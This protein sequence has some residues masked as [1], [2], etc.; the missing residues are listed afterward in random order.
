FV[1]LV[2]DAVL[3]AARHGDLYVDAVK[4]NDVQV[5]LN[6]DGLT[7]GEVNPGAIACTAELFDARR[8]LVAPL[9]TESV[10]ERLH[11]EREVAVSVS[12]AVVVDLL[13]DQRSR[14]GTERRPPEV[15]HDH[16]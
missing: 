11:V 13:A 5:R 3:S 14:R 15:G 2:G 1:V 4:V 6:S 8:E 12:V 7:G 10:G 16:I 9:D